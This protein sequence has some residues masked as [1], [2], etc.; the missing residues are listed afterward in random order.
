MRSLPN[1]FGRCLRRLGVGGFVGL[2]LALGTIGAH[3]AGPPR[4]NLEQA[5]RHWSLQPLQSPPVPPV[6]AGDRVRSSLDALLLARLEARGLTFAPAA[7][8]RTWLRRV[9]LDLTGLP[10]S[11][12]DFVAFE[13]DTTA[14]AH[15]RVV[16]RLLASPQYGERWGRHWLDVARYADTKDLVL[17]YGRDAIRPWA[18]TYRDYVIRAFNEDLPYHEFITDQLAA[19]L[20]T[21]AREPWRLAGLGFLTLGRQFDQNPH[22]QIDDQIDTTTRGFLGLTVACAR[23]HDHK[24]D[25]VGIDDYYALYGVFAATERPYVPPLIEDPAG[26]PGGPEFEAKLAKGQ[27]ELERHIDVEYARQTALFHRRFE[28]YFVRAVT[29]LPDL[30]ET[31]QFGL[32][33]VEEDF[34]PALM[35][36]TRELLG[37]RVQPD[38]R[39]FGPWARL[40]ALPEADYAAAAGATLEKAAAQANPL[41]IAALRQGA[42]AQRLAVPAV[43]GRL[44]SQLDPTP[45]GTNAPPPA[46][47]AETLAAA[48]PADRAELVALFAGPDGPL[49]FPR[50]E[51]PDHMS[52]PDKD[53]YGGLALAIEKLGAH[54]SNRPPARAMVV[55]DLADPP[56]PRVFQR[57]S[58]SRPGEVVARALPRVLTGGSVRPFGAGSGRLELARGIASMTNPLTARVWVNRVWMHHFGEPLVTSPADFGAR[59]EVPVQRE[60]LDWLTTEFLQGGMRLKPLHRRLVLSEAY[61][62][63]NSNPAAQKVDPDN[64][65]VG[66]FPRR[67]LELEAMRDSLLAVSGRLDSTLG[68]RPVEAP[69]EPANSRRTVY[70]LV[71][72]QNL[73]GLFRSF[74]FAAPDQCAERRP[75]TMVPQQ[76]LFALNSTFVLEL[77]R[78]LS[79]RTETAESVVRVER[80]FRQALGRNPT[81]AE[82]KAALR[83]VRGEVESPARDAAAVTQ[84]WVQLAQVLLIGNESVFVD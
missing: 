20:V 12:E 63:G 31:A 53:R 37:R 13:A 40:M 83:F 45:P 74:D 52:R 64:R 44:L 61:R 81:D 59:S 28:A 38:D 4:M 17:L 80:L 43:Y 65:L 84:A 11:Y 33:L 14:G 8:R 30:W 32:S 62:Q 68:G 24:Y 60:V 5:A 76:A 41:V 36:R 69:G 82:S 57:G 7:D 66:W 9:T 56:T 34:R 21:P 15:E 22:D 23:C 75:Q 25:P 26:V 3:S 39:V 71:D 2:W 72:R 18:Y 49:Y 6:R 79:E 54:A 46:V 67:R 35:R 10:P 55:R 51:A 70:S 42:L 50:R 58:P 16:D 73:P 19:D 29:T 48:A 78:Q 77:A 47:S 1:S 27:E